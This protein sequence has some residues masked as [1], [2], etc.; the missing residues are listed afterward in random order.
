MLFRSAGCVI[1]VGSASTAAAWYFEP[2]GGSDQFYLY[3]RVEGEKQYLSQDGTGNNVKLT[4][5]PETAIAL[6]ATPEA[7]KFFFKHS[8]QNKWL[9]H[10]NGGNGIRFYTSSSDAVNPRIS[11][12]YA[13]SYEIGRDPYGLDGQTFGI[14][15]NDESV[16]A[17]AL[18]AAAKA[19][20]DPQRLAGLD[21]LI[22]P[23]VLSNEGLLLVA[24][25]SEI[26][27]A[28]V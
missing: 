20:S 26:G 24:Q 2:A 6:S 28:H 12:T 21:M 16:T 4:D 7:G 11:I 10:S 23:D 5:A 8:G 18:T 19:N 17:V 22:R 25:N 14:A 9:Q 27:R 15:Y 13:D 3:T 1:E